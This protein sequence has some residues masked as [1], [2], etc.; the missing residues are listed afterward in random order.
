MTPTEYTRV[1]GLGRAR[2]VARTLRCNLDERASRCSPAPDR[3]RPL[4][5]LPNMRPGPRGIAPIRKNAGRRRVKVGTGCGRAPRM[6]A[7]ICS[8]KRRMAMLSARV[9]DEEPRRNDRA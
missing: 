2:C 6:T 7:I 3:G 4:P 8:M 5:L 1:G 9:R